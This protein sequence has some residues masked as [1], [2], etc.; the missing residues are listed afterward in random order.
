MRSRR[1]AAGSPGSGAA[2][3]RLVP[4]ALLLSARLA[5][6]AGAD[7]PAGTQC[8]RDPTRPTDRPD[9]ARLKPFT[10]HHG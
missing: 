6:P 9:R 5:R 4:T 2:E 1:A 3:R 7:S 8:G 10:A